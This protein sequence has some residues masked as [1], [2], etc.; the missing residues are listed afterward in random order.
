MHNNN[1]H[2]SSQANTKEAYTTTTTTTTT[3][4]M[5]T[6]LSPPLLT[7][8]KTDRTSFPPFIE[9]S[10]KTSPP[11][12]VIGEEVY[13]IARAKL[14]VVAVGAAAATTVTQ[15]PIQPDDVRMHDTVSEFNSINHA[16]NTLYF[17]FDPDSPLTLFGH[18]G[19]TKLVLHLSIRPLSLEEIAAV[20]MH[21][22][23]RRSE[24][25]LVV[26][27]ECTCSICLTTETVTSSCCVDDGDDEDET[28]WTT[29]VDCS[30]RIHTECIRRWLDFRSTCP[31]CRGRASF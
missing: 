25:Q 2:D 19:I 1:T 12:A 18:E 22:A 5:P 6:T 26:E 20:T 24:Q 29:L 15:I 11:V 30:H 27:D 3:T 10:L 4:T 8:P 7:F 17:S 21:N 23:H 14:V 16:G 28:K 31:M 9:L 13:R